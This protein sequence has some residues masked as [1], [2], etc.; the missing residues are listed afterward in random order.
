MFSVHSKS[1]LIEETCHFVAR[2]LVLFCNLLSL[3]QLLDIV[4]SLHKRLFGG[5]F[6]SQI[7]GNQGAAADLW[8]HIRLLME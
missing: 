6:C 8:A 7:I 4:C 3:E 5:S 2:A 1:Y